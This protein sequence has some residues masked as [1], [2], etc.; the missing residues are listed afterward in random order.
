MVIN[1]RGKQ[2]K[3][4][5]FGLAIVLG[6][7]LS[8][9]YVLLSLDKQEYQVFADTEGDTVDLSTLTVDYTAKDGD[10]LTNSLTSYYKISI[11]DG[12]TIT[13]RDATINLASTDDSNKRF[14]GITCEGSATINIEGE[15]LVKPL[16]Q[17]RPSIFFDEGKTL[18][19]QGTG[20]LNADNSVGVSTSA[21]G[22]YYGHSCG[23]LIIKS[24]TITAKGG[25]QSAAI[26][27][28]RKSSCGS[29]TI[30]GGTVTAITDDSGQA[31]I[32]GSDTSYQGPSQSVGLITISGGT[33]N[34]TGEVG[35]GSGSE[36][37]CEGILITGGTVNA[38]GSTYGPAIGA[39]Q[40]GVTDAGVNFI[41]ITGGTINARAGFVTA[42]IGS[43]HDGSRCGDITITGG[44][45]IVNKYEG[46]PHDLGVGI[47]SG[48]RAGG[49]YEKDGAT[50]GNITIGKDVEYLEV[51][52]GLDYHTTTTIGAGKGSTCGKITI[53]GV[54]YETI[55]KTP[56]IY[57]TQPSEVI[58]LINN[59]PNPVVYTP[60][61]KKKIDEAR[62]AYDSLKEDK[63]DEVTNYDDLLAAEAAYKAFE[64]QDKSEKV[65]NL[66]DDIGDVEY[67]N[68][69]KEK[70]DTAREEYDDLTN[71]Q[72]E[73]VDNYDTLTHDEEVYEHVDET[74]KKI[75][76]IGEVTTESG[77][78]ITGARESYDSLTPE[79]KNII[80]ES[81]V[82]KLEASE[83]TYKELT[84]KKPDNPKK[85]MSPVGVV[86]LVLGI[87]L[88]LIIC[89]YVLLFF[90]FNKWI[91]EEN[92]ATRVFKF[93]KKDGKARLLRVPFSFAKKDGK[94]K[95]IFKSIKFVYVDENE[96][97]KT[98][99]E[100]L[101]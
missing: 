18:T 16:Y 91:K 80:P 29:I 63:K 42:A 46:D 82:E 3:K 73:L 32:G 2:M 27:C 79:E 40:R 70:I 33:V 11:A 98:K 6:L 24:G 96:V 60:E 66:I 19:L 78:E 72:K 100:A 25:T 13:L 17:E 64:D 85:G 47:G 52:R 67:T 28:S 61:C 9:S 83:E 81:Y 7:S 86:F 37:V 76:A 5:I 92:D 50:C 62:K 23:N 53:A 10:I 31:A 71:D 89:A 93:G 74:V 68:E 1:K 77:D 94:V 14:P 41:T 69:C 48:V 56:F 36:S 22:A 39:Y 99:A 26:G 65:E 55:T 101:K 97:Y 21:I 87:I 58:E 8:T 12:A 44:I 45:I 90:V 84:E 54:E 43:S 4:R 34:A 35:I 59:I 75:D 49:E 15:N 30:E 95:F 57:P 38:T 88:L 20:V 51:N